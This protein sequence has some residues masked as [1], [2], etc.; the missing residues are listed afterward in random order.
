MRFVTHMNTWMS[1]VTHRNETCP[2]RATEEVWAADQNIEIRANARG[3]SSHV[4]HVN[5]SG[6]SPEN[7][8]WHIYSNESCPPRA[9][10]E[11]W[12]ADQNMDMRTKCACG[13]ASCHTYKWVMSRTSSR[14]VNQQQIKTWTC[15]KTYVR[16]RVMTP[17][18]MCW[19]VRHDSFTYVDMTWLL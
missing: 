18:W 16:Q 19:H 11:V 5:E 17:M 6:C 10:E 4:T 3:T 8:W 1:H 12:A 14:G 13:N 7:E 9:A 2:P 15:V